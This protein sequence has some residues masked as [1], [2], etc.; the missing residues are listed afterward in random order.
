ME[1]IVN[2]G[3]A[4]GNC[5]IP[6]MA[7]TTAYLIHPRRRRRCRGRTISLTNKHQRASKNF[8]PTTCAFVIQ[9]FDGLAAVPH[10]AI[11]FA[12][13]ADRPDPAQLTSIKLKAHSHLP[14]TTT[15]P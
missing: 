6:H 4:H 13:R 10:I 14:M 8:T 2:V 5:L 9:D 15:M 3:E 12:T 7:A 1:E 11:S